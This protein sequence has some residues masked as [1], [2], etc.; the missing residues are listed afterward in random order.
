MLTALIHPT[1][2]IDQSALLGADVSIGAYSVIGPNVQI[3]ASTTI[4]PHVQIVR[5]TNIG[6]SCNIHHGAAL[7]GDPQDLKYGEEATQL[8]VGDRTT[9]REFVT[10]NR[11]TSAHGKTEIGDDCLI[12][13][14]AHVAHDSV[15]GNRV[16]IAN[17]V[18]MGGHVIIEDAAIVGGLSAVHQFARIGKHAFVGG[19]SA[20]RKD[21]APYIKVSGDP[22]ELFGLNSVGLQRHG[23]PDELRQILKRAYRILFKSNHNL[24]QAIERVR[25][26]L[27]DSPELNHLLAFI[28]ASERGVSV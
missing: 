9:V 14:Y 4:G 27:P 22:L 19:K 6:E 28:E 10:L 12:M 8:M 3:G 7:G 1:A 25:A 20:V 2:V 16:V 15:I 5:D 23:F 17:A 11:G 18:Q 24:A 13:A 26:E 21:V